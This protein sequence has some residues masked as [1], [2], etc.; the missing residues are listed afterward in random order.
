MVAGRPQT[1]DRIA[2]GKEFIQWVK[3]HPDC[4]T[5][6]HFTTAQGYSSDT[7][8]TWC[9]EDNEFRQY[10]MLAKEL[11]GINR[12]NLMCIG[13]LDTNV[14]LK[15]E[16]RFDCDHKNDWKQEKEFESN[17]KKNEAQA[18]NEYAKQILDKLSENKNQIKDE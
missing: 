18:Q 6:P 3:D 12:L 13:K 9:N 1:Y 14:Y 4:L 10:Y 17:L 8:I 5:V 15:N 2:V 11:I 16:R 7:L